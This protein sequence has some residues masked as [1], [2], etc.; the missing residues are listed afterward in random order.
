MHDRI[1][2][3][4]TRFTEIG[5]Q[6]IKDLPIYNENLTV[7]AIGFEQFEENELLGVLIT[8]WFLNLILLSCEFKNWRPAQIGHEKLERQLPSL[9]NY[10]FTLGGDELI[11]EYYS[12][13]LVSPVHCFSNQ[14]QARTVA[15]EHLQRFLTPPPKEIEETNQPDPQRRRLLELLRG[16]K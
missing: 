1:T 13:S 12:I 15:L 16:K 4:I 7:E 9:E 2:N 3:L 6:Q 11:G 14:E 8:P 5:E 10:V